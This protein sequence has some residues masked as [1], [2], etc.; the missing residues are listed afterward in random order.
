MGNNYNTSPVPW[1]YVHNDIIKG[2][3]TIG[4]MQRD[5][6][7][8]RELHPG[9]MVWTDGMTEWTPLSSTDLI[10][11]I[12]FAPGSGS[13]A[14]PARSPYNGAYPNQAP[15][16]CLSRLTARFGSWTSRISARRLYPRCAGLSGSAYRSSSPTRAISIAKNQQYI[17]VVGRYSC[18]SR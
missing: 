11:H 12:M 3:V 17:Y 9:T 18:W 14:E 16:G 4:Q 5:Y 2:P 10:N 8:Y 6:Y 15:A 7:I 13:Q 1:Y